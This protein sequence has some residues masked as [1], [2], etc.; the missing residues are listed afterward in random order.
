MEGWRVG[1]ASGLWLSSVLA[2][3]FLQGVWCREVLDF[4]V[5]ILFLDFEVGG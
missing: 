1:N 5:V 2:L 4:W 3:G